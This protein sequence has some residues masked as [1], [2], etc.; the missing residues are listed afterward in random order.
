MTAIRLA[1]RVAFGT[2]LLVGS[3]SAAL[4]GLPAARADAASLAARW[5]VTQWREG[6]AKMPAAAA[7]GR[8]RAALLD[9]SACAPANAQFLDDL[10][11][12]HAL[13]AES[14]ESIPQ[15]HDLHHALL[16]E[17]EG[18]YQRAAELRPL[19][20]HGWAHLALVRHQLGQ[21]DDTMWRAYDAA[22][23]YGRNE[24]GVQR[25][26]GEVAFGNWSALGPAREHAMRELLTTG[27]PAVRKDLLALSSGHGILLGDARPNQPAPPHLTQRPAQ[28]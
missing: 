24:S 13:R 9:A 22:Y 27:A 8:V 23:A 5:E 12:I 3:V 18:Y 1:A 2:M 20:P 6:H 14:V 21:R 4:Y 17:A 7:W 28:P 11:F 19:F 26:L 25:I 16:R 10:G 15:L